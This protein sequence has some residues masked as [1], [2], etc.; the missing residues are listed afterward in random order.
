MVSISFLKNWL[1]QR[2][3]TTAKQPV[4]PGFLKEIGFSTHQAIKKVVDVC[5]IPDDLVIKIG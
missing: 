1:Y 3:A 2:R 5:D 4:S